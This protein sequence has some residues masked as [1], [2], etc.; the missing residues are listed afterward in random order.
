MEIQDKN[1]GGEDFRPPDGS[2]SDFIGRRDPSCS[3]ALSYTSKVG[4]VDEIRKNNVSELVEKSKKA[5]F[6]LWTLLHAKVRTTYEAVLCYVEYH[7]CV[8][9]GYTTGYSYQFLFYKSS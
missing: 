3:S 8:F 9:C 2:S 6:S 1:E 4:K 7:V 5:A